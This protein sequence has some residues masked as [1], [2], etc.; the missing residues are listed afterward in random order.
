MIFKQY[1][2]KNGL[3]TG[4]FSHKTANNCLKSAFFKY[5]DTKF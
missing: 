4:V 2:L 5:D 3:I 1:L